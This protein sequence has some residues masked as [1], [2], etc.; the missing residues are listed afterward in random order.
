MRTPAR[1][2]RGFT[3]VEMI[4]VIVITGIIGGM[5]AIFLRA[6]VQ[7][8]MD[9]TRRAEMTDIADTALRRLAR[10]LHAAV[11]N[12]V[13]LPAP[14]GSSYFEFMPTR[15]GGRYRVN[16]TGGSGSCGAAGDDLDFTVADTCFEIVGSPVTFYNGD[17][18]VIGSTQSDGS[19]PYQA[20]TSTNGVRRMIAAAGVGTNGFVKIASTV[21]FPASSELDGRRFEVV[22][23]DQQAVTYACLN[24]GTDANGDGTGT[25]TRYW[26][27]GFKVTQAAPPLA[28]ASAILA[29]KVSACNFVY[30][31]S[32]ARNSLVAVSLAITRGGESV[33]LYQELH[34]NNIP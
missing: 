27:Y 14:A 32:N 9:S 20:V 1:S 28:G 6:P 13:R 15:D 8:Y 34:V 30:N 26:A 22:P 2:H 31:T 21:P 23:Y 18:I 16:P 5:V 24:P 19:L 10:D 4:V 29:D 25:L 33:S 11:P 17:A 7:G 12:S 3:L